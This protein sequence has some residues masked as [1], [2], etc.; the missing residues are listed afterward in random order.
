M[1]L[2]PSMHGF[3]SLSPCPSR[4]GIPRTMASFALPVP[5]AARRPAAAVPSL[6]SAMPGSLPSCTHPGCVRGC[7][8]ARAHPHP[9]THTYSNSLLARTCPDITPE[10]ARRT[11]YCS[12][13]SSAASEQDLATFFSPCGMVKLVRIGGEDPTRFVH[14]RG[15]RSC[16]R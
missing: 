5:D 4:L 8:H 2:G 13:L 14:R 15:E 16:R 9:Y 10:E 12:N 7:T 1:L 11:V 3:D 6:S